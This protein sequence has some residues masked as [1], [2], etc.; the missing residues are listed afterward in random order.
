MAVQTSDPDLDRRIS[1][2]FGTEQP[3]LRRFALIAA[4]TMATIFAIYAASVVVRVNLPGYGGESIQLD[5]AAF[6]AAAKLALAGEPVAAF[7]P[8]RLEEA[9]ALPPSDT[10]PGNMLWLYPPA[11]HIAIMPFGL[12]PFSAAFL[13]YSAIVYAAFAAAVRPL[14]APLPGGLPLILAGPAV[15]LILQ[16]GNNSLLW[17]AGLVIALSALASGKGALAGSAIALLTLKPQLGLLVPVAL[18]AGGHWRAVLW[19]IGGTLVI[20]AV[21]VAALGADYWLHWFGTLKLMSSLM[22]TDLVRFNL[23][24][25][26]YALARFAGVAHETALA[27]QL[28]FSAGT[29][30]AVGWVWSRPVTS[31][32]KAATLCIAIPIATPYA[33]HYEFALVLVAAMFLARDGFGRTTGARAWL[34]A[35]WLGQVPGLA[36]LPHFPPAIYA[37]PL[38]TATLALC[39]WRAA[40]GAVCPA[41]LAAQ[42]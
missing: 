1:Q 9:M 31:D 12:L 4:I 20:V 35:L 37:A 5:F 10:P 38:L 28:G 11:W 26:W 24:I 17:T 22:Q 30:L 39:V 34:A 27:L 32:L 40:S 41:P 36:L 18:L 19:A 25:T 8:V 6:W 14:A 16:F 33:W 23:M 42:R 29:A 3:Y 15:V 13:I 7:H 2:A 21:S